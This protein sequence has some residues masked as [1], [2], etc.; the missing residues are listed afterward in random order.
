MFVDFVY[1]GQAHGEVAEGLAGCRWD[2]GLMRPYIDGRGV[3]CVTMNTGRTKWDA[4]T[5]QDIPIFEKVPVRDLMAAGIQSPVFNATSLRKEEWLMYDRQVLRA[6]RMRLK[7]WADLAAANTFGGFDGMSKM[8]LEHETMSD[9]GSA[10]VDMDGLTAGRNDF[11]LFQLQ[12]LPLPITHS[13]FWFS[14]RRLA[15]S[16]NGGTPL[17]STMAE[18]AGRRVAEMIER[19]TIGTL[20]GVTYGGGSSTPT[21]GRASSVFGYTNFTARLTKTGLTVPT[22]SNATT[23]VTQ[24]LAAR[25]QLYAANMFGPFMLYHSN[26]WDKFM[27][28]DYISSGGNNPNQTLRQRLRAIEGISDV[29]RLDFWTPST[30]Y[31]MILVQMTPDV[32]RAV[33]GMNMTTIQWESQGGMRLNFK[34]MC[35]MVPQ[36]RADYNGNCG[37]LHFTQ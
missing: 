10:M 19:T 1:N 31:Q 12:G 16:R 11:P 37:I 17:D 5:Q 4:K 22:G 7:A 2:S 28:N 9:P 3:K 35:I 14:S 27:D 25:D 32:A 24:V 36:L 26:D 20:A 13:D 21:Y 29:R 33:V 8:V 34:V 30:P 18:A 6:A 15:L 23:T